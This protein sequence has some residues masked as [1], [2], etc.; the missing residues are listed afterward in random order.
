MLRNACAKVSPFNWP[1]TVRLVCFSEE[2]LCCNQRFRLCSS[3]HLFRSSVVT[4]NISP[5]PS[6]SLPVI[7]GV[8]TY[9]KS[10]LLERTCESHMRSGNVHGIRPGTC[11]FSDADERSFSDIQSCDASSAA[12]NPVRKLPPLSTSVCLDLKRLF[13]LRCRHQ[14][15][16]YDH[17]CSD[18]QSWQISCK[19]LHVVMIYDLQG[20]KKSTVMQYQEIQMSWN[21]G[22]FLPSPPTRL[23]PCSGISLC[24]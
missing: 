12:D 19:I 4:W 13:C 20:L 23:F 7:S 15:S 6:Q 3:V 10:S 14:C 2:I 16:F 8:C 11:W 17:G 9:T 5:A 21:H 24:F 1:L 22:C 18:I